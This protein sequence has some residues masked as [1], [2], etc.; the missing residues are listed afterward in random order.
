[1]VV[2]GQ[3]ASFLASL[4]VRRLPGVGPKA[5]E[6]LRAGGVETVGGL[7]A[8]GDEDLRRLLPGSVGPVL[9][10]RARGIDPRG[11]ELDTERISI[12]VENTFERDLGDPERLHHELRAMATEVAGRLQKT[13]QVARTVTTKLR[14]ADFSIRSRS[15]SLDVGIDDAQQIGDLA[16]RLL[17]RGL[18][19]RPG[20]L[21]LVGVGVSG[22]AAYRQLAL[23]GV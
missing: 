8:L 11:L 22:L 1:V 5:Q 4:D 10:D 21:R 16:C 9:R 3:E 13:G 19:D 12:S 15:A 17:D 23:S 20:A 2:P 18:R 14:Y 6:R 7:A